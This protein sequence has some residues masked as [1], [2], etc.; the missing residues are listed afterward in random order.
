[1]SLCQVST[2]NAKVHHFNFG[3]DVTALTTAD[4]TYTP[5][6]F[7][8]TDE[9]LDV[10]TETLYPERVRHFEQTFQ[11]FDIVMDRADRHAFAIK[12]AID[13]TVFNNH[14]SAGIDLDDG[15]FAAAT[16]G[17]AGN[18]VILSNTNIPEMFDLI[19]EN[20]GTNNAQM[21]KGL[22]V[23]MDPKR[24]TLL[25]QY[26]RGAGFEVADDTIVNGFR[27]TFN[28]F[29]VYVSNNLNTTATAGTTMGLAGVY[30]SM[31]LALPS[32]GTD[33]RVKDGVTGFSGVEIVTTQIHGTRVWT[34]MAPQLA[35]IQ[36]Q[37]A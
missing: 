26:T 23:V 11:N 24:F 1:M 13:I 22:F 12:D 3:A 6:D 30:G 10:T 32:E 18:P 17:G 14:A 35:R 28:G 34:K 36:W 25:T 7:T 21:D 31:Y 33:F 37:T 8:Y 16:N 2:S 4:G 27:G 19:L 15:N 5:Q 20:L 29:D 9:T